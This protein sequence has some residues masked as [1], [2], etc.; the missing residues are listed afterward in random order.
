MA[1]GDRIR[2][3]ADLGGVN[4]FGAIDQRIVAAGA[5]V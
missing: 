1:A 3:E 2:I 5:P 4:P